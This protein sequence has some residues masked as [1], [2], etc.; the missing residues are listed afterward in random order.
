M[1]TIILV[2]LLGGCILMH[3]LMMRKSN[4][5]ENSQNTEGQDKTSS[6]DK[7]HSGHGC[8]H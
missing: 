7:N 5:S 6:N 1:N 8:C 3:F 2:I 4:H